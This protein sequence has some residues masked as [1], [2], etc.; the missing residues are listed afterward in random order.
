MSQ[1]VQKQHLDALIQRQ[2]GLQFRLR[3]MLVAL[4]LG[5]ALIVALYQV[6]A[7]HFVDIGG[8]DAAYARGF[9]DPEFVERFPATPAYLEGS[10]GTA[11]WSRDR[12]FLLFPQAGLPGS[13]TLRLRGWRADGPPPQVSVLLNGRD[14]LATIQTSGAWE[15]HRFAITGG[16]LKATDIFIELRSETTVLP[17]DGRKVGVLLDTAVYRVS[18][19]SSGLI[20]PYPTQVAYGAVA[21]G[22]AW[23]LWHRPPPA[24]QHR[25][26]A[27]QM[28]V[29]PWSIIVLIGL[30]FLLL[31]RLQPPLYPY[32]L[33]WLLPGVNLAL[34][35]AL[36]LRH[37]PALL[38]RR[39][40]LLD[41]LVPAGV[42]LWTAGVLLIARDHLTLSRP[43]VENDFG[44][45]AG[46]SASLAE[47]F[48]A[49]GFYNLGYPLLLWLVR[50]LTA[51]N[52]FLAGRLIAALS[53]AVVLLATCR[54][55]RS[56]IRQITHHP[57][58]IT[59]H[60]FGA[61]LALL[62]LGLS[63]FVV[64]YA[65]YVGSDMP[66]AATMTLAVALLLSVEPSTTGEREP[67]TR[68]L[69]VV[70]I[71][72]VVAGC[73]FLMRHP[74]LVLLPWGIVYC[75][76]ATG[77][78][79]SISQGPVRQVLLPA[80]FALGFLLAALP[81]LTVNTLQTG[82]PLYNQ[83]AK[84]VWLAVYG[85]TDWGR[86]DEA[87]NTIGLAEVILR[88]PARFF[89]NWWRNLAGFTGSG[90][91]D[92][93]EFGRAVQLRLLGWPANWLAITGLLAW[94]YTLRR[95][96]RRFPAGMGLLLLIALYVPVVSMA[97][98]LPRFFL[99]LAPIYAVAAAGF[100]G[101]VASLVSRP[102]PT[103]MQ[104][105]RTL[106]AASLLL[107][108]LL[109]NGFG[110]GGRHVLDHQPADEVAA[111]RLVQTTLAP[112]AQV[113][114]R[115]PADASLARYSAIAHRVVPWTDTPDHRA[116]ADY[117]LWH[118]A[119]GPPPLPEPAAVRVGAAEGYT[120][121]RLVEP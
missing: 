44:V 48:R 36:A 54:L 19:G 115:V 14:L 15:E 39:P 74:G 4:A 57:S 111:I 118:A 69:L 29:R 55:A 96:I 9:H 120:L 50:P 5:A 79:K 27:S 53:G 7:R 65:L 41:A 47:V 46:R 100:V 82:Q 77:A 63:P 12:S 24:R 64:E 58:P 2:G 35:T 97:F 101:K 110:I 1:T 23:L 107:L 22:L 92:T 70:A 103:A 20:T 94:V 85:N 32:P 93:S 45:F 6:P 56:V 112:D 109:G 66:F 73:A 42:A 28:L 67:G 38:V 72:G 99:P 16:L 49:D 18:P 83:Q 106:L 95:G 84:N 11:R 21:A 43:G 60:S 33:R 34:A 81:Q 17:D 3:V 78:T 40:A 8:Y 30:A 37:G 71:A 88:D 91:E 121:Y 51:D 119:F 86:W 31:Y 13:I 59:E 113:L 61:L 89:G 62:M 105:Q 80:T 25:E 87:P 108:V 117:L 102:A 26:R 68:R 75:V 90:A 114:A 76:F 10:N 52:A 104:R 116:K 98:I